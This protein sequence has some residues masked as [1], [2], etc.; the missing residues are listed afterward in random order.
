MRNLTYV[1][2]I[3]RSAV[4]SEQNVMEEEQFSYNNPT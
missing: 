1:G 3:F 2:G 4:G